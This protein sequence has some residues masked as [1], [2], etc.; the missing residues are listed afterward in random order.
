MLLKHIPVVQDTGSICH[1]WNTVCSFC[2]NKFQILTD[3]QII[4]LYICQSIKIRNIHQHIGIN[5]IRIIDGT[6][7]TNDIRIIFT[8]KSGLQHRHCIVR[9]TDLQFNIIMTGIKP[10]LNFFKIRGCFR[11]VL[12]Q[13]DHCFSV[14]IILATPRQ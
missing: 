6:A 3:C 8:N 10:F 7:N 13:F 1:I 14:F 11:L 4:F 5:K 12:Y 9:R 2:W